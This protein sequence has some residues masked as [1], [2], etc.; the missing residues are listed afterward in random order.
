MEKVPVLKDK[1]SCNVELTEV[2]QQSVDPDLVP[3][4][5]NCKAGSKMSY[6]EM[7]QLKEST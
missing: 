2:Q 7:L 3:T 1:T 5:I 4:E 6:R